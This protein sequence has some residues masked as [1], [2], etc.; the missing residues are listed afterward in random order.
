MGL[1][2]EEESLQRKI[3]AERM[4]PDFLDGEK[5][6]VRRVETMEKVLESSRLRHQEP[7]EYLQDRVEEFLKK[8]AAEEASEQAQKEARRAR[9]LGRT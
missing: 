5:E 3:W 6:A 1:N 9:F 4:A 8:E 2:E 7:Q